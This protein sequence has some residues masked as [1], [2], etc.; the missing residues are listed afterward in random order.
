[1]S[2]APT[3]TTTTAAP[4]AQPPPTGRP[5]ALQ[6]LEALDPAAA[7]NTIAGWLAG[8]PAEAKDGLP[9]WLRDFINRHLNPEF[10]QQLGEKLFATRRDDALDLL[11]RA[12]ADWETEQNYGAA[13]GIYL[14]IIS[15]V[16]TLEQAA[17]ASS[18]VERVVGFLRDDPGR[19][20]KEMVPVLERAGSLPLAVAWLALGRYWLPADGERAREA[21]RKGAD[22]GDPACM[23]ALALELRRHEPE[24][25]KAESAAWFAKA[26]GQKYPAGQYHHAVDLL[27]RDGRTNEAIALLRTAIS[28]HRADA[29]TYPGALHCEGR[30]VTKS[31]VYAMKLFDD[32]IAAGDMYACALKAALLMSGQGMQKDDKLAMELLQRGAA[33]TNRLCLYYLGMAFM[34]GDGVVKDEPKG[35]RLVEQSAKLGEPRAMKWLDSAPPESAR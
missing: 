12:A 16:P 15:R 14:N 10:A 29:M 21:F 9:S 25:R 27:E 13:L 1:V 20:T 18:R 26:S 33:Q 17:A 6:N 19:I 31:T 5:E 22:A 28:N 7:V 30:G 3:N 4:V 24:A 8:D 11:A 23:V 35:R 2:A 34:Y 32:A